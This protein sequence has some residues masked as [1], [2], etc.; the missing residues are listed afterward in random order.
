MVHSGDKDIEL[1]SIDRFGSIEL[2]RTFCKKKH[3]NHQ[4]IRKS[5]GMVGREKIEL[6]RFGSK[7]YLISIVSLYST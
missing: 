7:F 3:R 4:N 1:C 6:V 2:N 5:S